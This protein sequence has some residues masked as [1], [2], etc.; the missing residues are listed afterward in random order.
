MDNSWILQNIFNNTNFIRKNPDNN[1]TVHLTPGFYG[2]PERNHTLTVTD[3]FPRGIFISNESLEEK[4]EARMVLLSYNNLKTH[5]KSKIGQPKK[6][7][8]N[9]TKM[10]PKEM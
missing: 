10:H 5:I 1:T 3:F 6:I 7:S 2:I 8:S 4:H 9:T